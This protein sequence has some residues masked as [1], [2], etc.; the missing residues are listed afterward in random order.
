MPHYG[1][2]AAALKA[3]IANL[4]TQSAPYLRSAGNRL[5]GDS[6]AATYP[7]IAIRK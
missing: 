2:T 5:R 7:A 4:A 6:Q 3:M 1:K